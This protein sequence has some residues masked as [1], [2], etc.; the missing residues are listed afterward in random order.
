MHQPGGNYKAGYKQL[1]KAYKE[2]KIKAIGISN[3]EGEYI[4]DILN[5]FSI[6]PQV[7]QVECYPYFQQENLRKITEP[8][9]IKIMCWYPLG[10]GD[11]SLM[12]ENIITT[13]ANKYNKSTAQIM[14]KWHIQMGFIVI[15][16]SKNLD[17]IRDNFDLFDFELTDEEIKKY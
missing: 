11:K 7:E 1:E 14:L 10:H 3:F 16:G 15:P 9:N 6:I 8:K 13:L 12:E 2:G 17:H 5:N 4:L